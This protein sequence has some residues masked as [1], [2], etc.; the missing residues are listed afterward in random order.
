L[1]LI[2]V[3][4]IIGVLVGLLLPAIQKV[5]ESAART[6]SQNN[7][8]QLT[9]AVHKIADA[10][11]D[12]LL[13]CR[14]YSVHM[15]CVW[16]ALGKEYAEGYTSDPESPYKPVPMLLSPADP[17]VDRQPANAGTAQWT[18]ADGKPFK[19]F[20]AVSSFAC[21]AAAFAD[22]AQITRI[23]DGTSNTIAFAE[24]Y[25]TCKATLFIVVL[26][27]T[28]D[29]DRRRPSFADR[30]IPKRPDVFPIVSGT[31]PKTAPSQPGITFQVR[32]P[33]DECNPRIPQTPH[34]GGMIVAF[35][36]GSV[37]TVRPG[38]ESGAFWAAV[39][40]SAGDVATL[41]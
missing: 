23:E 18:S 40:P 17:S 30:D 34:A 3:I 41:D 33:L 8:R 9:L 4:A 22:G 39:T 1:E 10:N 38:I 25:S 13:D 31:P 20:R 24:H 35:L 19:P 28:V 36:D 7:L 27:E 11:G 5:R 6:Q 12:R 15:S 29:P 2:V 21:N 32:P 37:R 14:R 16:H 26:G